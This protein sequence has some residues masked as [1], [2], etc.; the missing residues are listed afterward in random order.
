MVKWLE[1]EEGKPDDLEVWGVEKVTYMLMD[2]KKFVDN[3]TL[4]EELVVKKS[5][6]KKKVKDNCLAEEFRKGSKTVDKGS[7][8]K[9]DGPAKKKSSQK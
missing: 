2:L 1:N 8:K 5:K 9:K 4:A 6:G 3:G 7:P